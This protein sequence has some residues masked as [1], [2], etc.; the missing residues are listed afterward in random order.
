LLVCDTGACRQLA[1]GFVPVAVPVHGGVDA[2]SNDLSWTAGFPIVARDFALQYGDWG[3]PGS[4]FGGINRWIEFVL[5]N[6]SGSALPNASCYGDLSAIP[7]PTAAQRHIVGGIMAGANFLISV[8]AAQ[9]IA[10][11]TGLAADADRL[12]KELDRLRG[13]FHA[14]YWLNVSETYCPAASV[15][16][17][18]PAAM[19]AMG[20]GTG[21]DDE[22]T[23]YLARAGLAV[24]ADVEAR[25]YKL[26]VGNEGAK[27]LFATLSGLGARGHDAALQMALRTDFPGFGYWVS[28]GAT[29]CWESWT[30]ELERGDDHYHGSRNHGWLCGGMGEWLYK[31]LAGV[32][33]LSPGFAEVAVAPKISASLGPD[34]VQI[35]AQTGFGPIVLNW[36]RTA[37]IGGTGD[38]TVPSVVVGFNIPVGVIANVTMPLLAARSKVDVVD[39]H[40]PRTGPTSVLVWN[41][42]TVASPLPSGFISASVG[43]DPGGADG[44]DVLFARV[45]AGTYRLVVQ[46]K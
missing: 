32:V 6:S 17:C 45:V 43:P 35:A 31:S 1:D 41:G 36:T 22:Y 39:T 28:Q 3:V 13:I 30:N 5:S 37:S 23:P 24:L 46:S 40:A 11:A 12:G 18:N 34:T 4:H 29:T 7:P 2:V 33:P 10:A 42:S 16:T 44:A 27:R 9:E 38:A 20:W 19:A 14:T 26:T 15:Q 25:G 8:E 21:A